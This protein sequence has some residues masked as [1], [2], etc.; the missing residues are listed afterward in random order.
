MIVAAVVAVGAGVGGHAVATRAT[1]VRGPVPA[2]SAPVRDVAL[3]Y[4]R[5]ATTEDCGLTDALTVHAP[6][7]P[8]TGTFAWC[9]DPRM[10]AFSGVGRPDPTGEPAGD[11]CVPFTMRTTAS[12]DETIQ[13]GTQDWMLCFTR[14]SAGWRVLDQGDS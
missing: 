14:T 2:P 5:A 11:Y 6:D 7:G 9:R 10:L 12:S 13:A 3:A 4:L 1:E 8:G